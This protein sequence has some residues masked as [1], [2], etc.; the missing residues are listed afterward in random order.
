MADSGNG[1]GQKKSNTGRASGARKFSQALAMEPKPKTGAV[2]P[3]PKSPQVPQSV[4]VGALPPMPLTEAGAAAMKNA[5]GKAAGAPPGTLANPVVV[6]PDARDSA[7]ADLR[8]PGFLAFTGRFGDIREP[9]AGRERPTC[10]PSQER[11]WKRQR[12]ITEEEMESLQT[13]RRE[14]DLAI[15]FAAQAWPD[16]VQEAVGL[17]DKGLLL[18]A[19]TVAESGTSAMQL[20][21]GIS[22]KGYWVAGTLQQQR[23]NSP[24]EARPSNGVT[25]CQCF[26]CQKQADVDIGGWWATEFE[27]RMLDRGTKA[28]MKIT[29]WICGGCRWGCRTRVRWSQ[30][31]WSL[32]PSRE[33]RGL[34]IEWL[35]KAIMLA[36]NP[37][38]EIIFL[39]VE[40]E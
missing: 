2:E 26:A 4:Q 11:P 40:Q 27:A 21:E 17:R 14:T 9:P 3:K 7:A 25:G 12:N 39:W 8:P 28:E 6:D 37:E 33:S 10:P 18:D 1:Q 16:V 24:R 23:Q 13:L 32:W 15:Q 22:P 19:K 20:Q 30:D 31:S 5:I 29:G 34:E 38:W 36:T 35:S